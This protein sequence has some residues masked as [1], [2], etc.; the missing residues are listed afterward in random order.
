MKRDLLPSFMGRFESMYGISTATDRETLDEVVEQLDKILFDD[1]I[2]RKSESLLKFTEAGISD[3]GFAWAEGSKPTGEIV[4][5]AARASLATEPTM[6]TGIR[7]Y[8]LKDLLFLVHVHSQVNGIAAGLVDRVLQALLYEL[9]TILLEC[10]KRVPR[11]G[12]GGML[13]VRNDVPVQVFAKLI[14]CRLQ[15]T[16]EVEF[17][18]QTLLQYVTEPAAAI[19]NEIY[20]VISQAYSRRAGEGELERELEDLKKV[21]YDC[22]RATGVEFVCFKPTKS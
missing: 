8:L 18:H 21:L 5:R 10:L 22:R 17:L 1:F 2:K 9:G 7:P 16:L 19:L 15:A 20:S 11:L 13:K 4:C 6:R 3:D 14:P 12:M